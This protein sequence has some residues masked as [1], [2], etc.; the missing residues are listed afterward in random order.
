MPVH[1]TQGYIKL[2]R[3]EVVSAESRLL[4]ILKK[5]YGGDERQ[6]REEIKKRRKAL[7]E[8]S[9]ARLNIKS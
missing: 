9:A 7:S 4:E 3:K 1:A 2:L 8:H 6:A 5:R